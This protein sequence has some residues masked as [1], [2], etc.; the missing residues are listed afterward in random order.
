MEIHTSKTV[1]W[2]SGIRVAI[3]KAELGATPKKQ[4]GPFTINKIDSF[5]SSHPST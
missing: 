1:I 4:H 5:I 3:Q 2:D